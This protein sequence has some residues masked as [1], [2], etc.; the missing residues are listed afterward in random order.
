[1]WRQGDVMIESVTEIPSGAAP[2]PDRVLALGTA[3]GNAH[4]I[5]EDSAEVYEAG[6][7]RYLRI[8][9]GPAH[10]IHAEHGTI[11]LP[12]GVYRVWFQ[13]EYRGHDRP[14]GWVMD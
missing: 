7:E 9:Q 13:R 8:E 1:M 6:L 10:I 2:T 5:E 12:A 4:R 14:T 11:E 3:T